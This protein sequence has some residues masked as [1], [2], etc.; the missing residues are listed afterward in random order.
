M[1]VMSAC[2]F[3]FVHDDAPLE[4]HASFVPEQAALYAIINT[5]YDESGRRKEE[6]ELKTS[7]SWR[8]HSNN[9]WSI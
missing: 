2:N 6:N 5:V 1:K 9:C 7:R 4:S 3:F 8:T